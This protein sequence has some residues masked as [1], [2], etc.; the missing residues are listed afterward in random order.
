MQV[1][2]QV[3]FAGQWGLTLA[4]PGEQLGVAG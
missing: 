1:V 4:R 3:L 2:V